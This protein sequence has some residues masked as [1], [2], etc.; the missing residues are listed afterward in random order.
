MRRRPT[1]QF[2]LGVLALAAL[3]GC[4]ESARLPL[5]AGVGPDPTLPAAEQDDDPD[6]CTS[7]PP[8]GGRMGAS[9]WPAPGTAVGVFAGGLDHPRWVYVL[10]NGDVLV[11]ET[12]AP[13]SPEDHKG[14]KG[15]ITKMVMKRAGSGTPSANRIRLLRD[16]DGDGVAETRTVFLEGLNS[17]FG[18]ALVGGDFYVANTDAVLR[19]AYTEGATSL[20]G[21]GVKV[22]DLP[23]GP[24]QPPLDA[25]SH[26]Q[27]RR[28]P[29][30]R[31]GG[32]QQQRGREGHGARDGPG[33]HLGGE[34]A[35]RELSRVRL[36]AA[37]PQRARVG[38]QPDVALDSGERARRA[39]RAISCPTTSPR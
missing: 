14:I 34:S 29:P 10:P 13:P 19:F 7:P 4:G 32:L 22:V 27:P 16:A 6:R 20:D 25:Q 26:R 8:R 15:R 18:M 3:A 28:Q 5:S 1:R 30:L 35:R 21:P 33:R 12:A 37:Q 23:A 17:P 9:P 38:A 2:L 11:A 39:R 31:D 36:G 24:D